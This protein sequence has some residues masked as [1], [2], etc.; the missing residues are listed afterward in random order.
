MVHIQ[1]NIAA[2][3]AAAEAARRSPEDQDIE[4]EDAN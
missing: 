3:V 2:D 1:L 4:D